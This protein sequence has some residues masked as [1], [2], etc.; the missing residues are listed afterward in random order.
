VAQVFAAPIVLFKDKAYVGG[1]TIENRG[2]SIADFLLRNQVTENVL[3][4]EIKTPLSPLLNGREYR[5]GTYRFSD[6]LAGAMSQVLKYKHKLQLNYRQVQGEARFTAFDPKCLIVTGDY[7]REVRP[8]PAKRSSFALLRNDSRNVTI[9][10]YDELFERVSL[11][12][13]LL[14]AP[15]A[16][17]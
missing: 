11:L 12:I 16:G 2:G 15:R 1:K 13:R 10:T 6:D 4:M 14:E 8:D 17:A 7:S 3:I 5:Q 9:V